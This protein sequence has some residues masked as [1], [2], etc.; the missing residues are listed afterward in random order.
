MLNKKPLLGLAAMS[1]FATG[2][3]FAQS[4]GDKPE[5]LPPGYSPTSGEVI[6]SGQVDPQCGVATIYDTADLVFG[7]SYGD[8]H[9]TVDIINNTNED[10]KITASNIDTSSFD[11]VDEFSNSKVYVKSEG[12]VQEDQD[13][14]KWQTTGVSITKEQLSQNSELDLRARVSVEEDELEADK[15]Y[16]VKTTWTVECN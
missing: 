15:N 8:S 12:A 1:I 3:A 2:S 11:D 7:D 10:I 4:P 13:L 9:A 6:F 14:E 5:D 16:V